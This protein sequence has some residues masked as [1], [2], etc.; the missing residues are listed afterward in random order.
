MFGFIGCYHI[1]NTVDIIS[2]LRI[3]ISIKILISNCA[4]TNMGVLN[5]STLS[6]V[7]HSL[8]AQA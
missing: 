6:S 2:C 8:P 7:N 5:T 1:K 3:G 4:S